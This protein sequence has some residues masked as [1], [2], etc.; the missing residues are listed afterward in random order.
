MAKKTVEVFTSDLSE[1]PADQTVTFAVN[2]KGYEI[3]L[4]D[5]EAVTFLETFSKYVDVSRPAANVRGS[6]GRSASSKAPSNAATI[7]KWAESQ[8]IA[9]PKRGRIPADVVKAFNEKN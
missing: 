1:A 5:A 4:T 9:V 7:R 8:G 2:G 3:D 6:K